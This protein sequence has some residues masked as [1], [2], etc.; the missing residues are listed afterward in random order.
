MLVLNKMISIS[1]QFNRPLHEVR[2]S[3]IDR[4]N[5]RCPYCMPEE[6]YARHY[7]FLQEKEW[8][9]FAEIEHLVKLFVKVGVRKVRLTGGEPLLRPNLEQLIKRLAQIKELEDLALT[10]NGALLGQCADSLKKAGLQRLTV[11]LD[12]LD[13]RVFKYMS[14]RKGNVQ[15][16]LEGIKEA[17]KAGF[18]SIKINVVVQK[19]VNDQSILDLVEYFRG[20]SHVLRFIEYM[21]VGNCNH[22]QNKYVVPS[23]EILQKINERYPLKNLEPAHFGEVAKRYEFVDGKG[24]VGFISSITQPFCNSCTRGRLSTDGKIFTCLFADHGTDLKRPLRQGASD[25]DL[26]KLIGQ[27]WAKREDRYSDLRSQI[28]STHHVPHKVEMFQIGG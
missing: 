9:T 17:E 21:D 5:F 4:C 10:T 26:L 8:L 18:H 16:T 11:S 7:S 2:I 24:E 6:E 13:S 12:T 19:G 25:E 28:Y 3:V 22:W 23:A 15:K 14:G 27:I 20:S 1:D